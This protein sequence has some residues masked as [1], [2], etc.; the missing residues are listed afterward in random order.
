MPNAET[1]A[2]RAVCLKAVCLKAVATHALALPDLRELR[3][4]QTTWTPRQTEEYRASADAQADAFWEKVKRTPAYPHLTPE[5]REFARKRCSELTPRDQNRFSW[6]IEAYQVLLWA[7]GILP[8]LPPFYRLAAREIL[9]LRASE[10]LAAKTLRN[11]AEIE[12]MRDTAELW[13]WRSRTRE[14]FEAGSEDPEI[15][16]IVK[17]T[18]AFAL[19]NGAIEQVIDDDFGVEG[20]AYCDLPEGEWQG[21]TSVTVERHLALNWL[22]RYAPGDRWDETP[23]DT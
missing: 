8:E 17:A 14:M 10:L 12:A 13:R 4:E 20:H 16:T 15:R 21:L 19:E 2:L 18:A 7:L 6:R 22:C 5:E 3:R 1:V 23:T 11:S 9:D